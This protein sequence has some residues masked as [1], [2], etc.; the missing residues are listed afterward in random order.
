MS[1]NEEID[2][3]IMEQFDKVALL[4]KSDYRFYVIMNQKQMD[5]LI[6]EVTLKSECITKIN[7]KH[8]IYGDAYLIVDDSCEEITAMCKFL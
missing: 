7:S 5:K 1:I 4:P 3:K 6:D 2:K 8:G